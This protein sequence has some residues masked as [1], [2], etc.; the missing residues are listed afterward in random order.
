MR[1]KKGIPTRRWEASERLI[2]Q[3]VAHFYIWFL[4]RGSMMDS[5][6]PNPQSTKRA[7]EG[8]LLW[9][10]CWRW[11]G[12]HIQRDSPLLPYL[13]FT[14]VRWRSGGWDNLPPPLGTACKILW[15]LCSCLDHVLGQWG[16]PLFLNFWYASMLPDVVQMLHV[17]LEK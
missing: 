1:G 10:W 5:M 2:C 9:L 12:A 3:Q 14:G 16:C 11:G 15:Q 4:V 6:A 8:N 17:V 7:K 13:S